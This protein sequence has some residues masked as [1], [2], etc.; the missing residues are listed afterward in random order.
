MESVSHAVSNE[1]VISV[2]SVSHIAHTPLNCT[3][4]IGLNYILD[5]ISDFLG[6]V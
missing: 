4:V 2:V 1:R 3:E 6:A 5:P